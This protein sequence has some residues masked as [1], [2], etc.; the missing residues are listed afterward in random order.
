MSSKSTGATFGEKV[1]G[2]FDLFLLFGRGIKPFEKEGTFRHAMQSLWFIVLSLPFNFWGAWVHHPQGLEEASYSTVLL[3]TTGFGLASFIVGLGV[4]YLFAVVMDRK[5]RFWLWFQVGNWMA[6]P[7]LA[8]GVPVIAVAATNHFARP[9]IDGVLTLLTYY[10]VIVSAC[11]C[12]RA[13]K[14]GWEMAGFYACMW[15]FIAQQ[16]YN[17]M[18]WMHGYSAP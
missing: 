9:E 2:T 13:L 3:I 6:I 5:D 16:I 10:G 11:V 1:K 4:S 18:F 14:I 12:F 15:V 17:V 8:T 7:G